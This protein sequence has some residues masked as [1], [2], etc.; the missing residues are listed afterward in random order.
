MTDKSTAF[1]VTSKSRRIGI[2]ELSEQLGK[3][4][5]QAVEIEETVLGALMLERDALS[6]VIDI[7]HVE[8]FY[9]ESH[10]SIF[11]AIVALFNNSEPVDIKTVTHQLR[12]NG[13]LDGPV[14][15]YYKNGRV[16][17]EGVFKNGLHFGK[18]RN[19]S[20]EGRLI[21]IDDQRKGN[22]NPIKTTKVE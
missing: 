17:S 22:L 10:Q 20:K 21:S 14:R 8:S 13:K 11:E 12:K 7:L 3:L 16:R 5:P 19:Y 9:K 18:W 4:P 1:K 6:N 2:S 15:Y